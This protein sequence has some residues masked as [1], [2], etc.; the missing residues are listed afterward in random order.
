M[1]LFAC[2]QSI[3][4]INWFLENLSAET[5]INKL[6]SAMMNAKRTVTLGFVVIGISVVFW[7]LI[8]C[9]AEISGWA[10]FSFI[11]VHVIKGGLEAFANRI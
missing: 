1:L 8:F 11:F 9:V 6:A 3:L 4:T 10:K 2:Y 7:L 5:Q